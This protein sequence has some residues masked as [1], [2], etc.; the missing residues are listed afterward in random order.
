MARD[1]MGDLITLFRTFRAD[2]SSS[3][4]TDG[5]VQ[6]IFDI[7][8]ERLDRISLSPDASNVIFEVPFKFIE[9]APTLIDSNDVAVTVN[10]TESNDIQGIYV[11]DSE[12]SL[13]IRIKGWRHNLFY[14]LSLAYRTISQADDAWDMYKRGNVQFT[15][16]QFGTMADEFERLGFETKTVSLLRG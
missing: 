4:Y 3:V 2:I 12:Q 10:A 11:F 13:P 5:Q 14:T 1:N 15:R 9:G 6:N 16:R 7:N 8:R